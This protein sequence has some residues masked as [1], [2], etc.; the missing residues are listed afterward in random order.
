MHKPKWPLGA[1]SSFVLSKPMFYFLESMPAAS[2][3]PA[4]P[5]PSKLINLACVVLLQLLP[6]TCGK[7][8]CNATC[9]P[10]LSVCAYGAVNNNNNNNNNAAPGTVVINNNNNNNYGGNCGGGAHLPLPLTLNP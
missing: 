1:L 9:Q 6:C 5:K 3:S 8:R 2:M 4:P 7:A 10:L